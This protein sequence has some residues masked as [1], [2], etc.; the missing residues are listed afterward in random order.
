MKRS[1]ARQAMPQLTSR[2]VSPELVAAIE[3][4]EIS[5]PWSP[6]FMAF[7]EINERYVLWSERALGHLAMTMRSLAGGSW[8]ELCA[9][10]G[11]LAA[12][13]RRRGISITATDRRPARDVARFDVLLDD[14]ALGGW[15]AAL[16][17]FPPD[18]ARIAGALGRIREH[19]PVILV[20]P[21]L[22]GVVTC[23]GALACA[24]GRVARLESLESELI[25]RHDFCMTMGDV[26]SIRR[27]ARVFIIQPRGT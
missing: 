16:C 8:V 25:S 7:C 17:V 2:A 26:R 5:G 6:S 15:D 9:G 18:D 14:V 27:H 22:D 10:D 24:A 4:G 21:A 1:V 23:A 12:A 13:L 19:I 11:T 20:T 3:S